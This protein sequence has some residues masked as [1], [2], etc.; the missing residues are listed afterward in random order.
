[1]TIFG[2]YN[3]CEIVAPLPVEEGVA[4]LLLGV[5]LRDLAD[6]PS[7]KLNRDCVL[8]FDALMY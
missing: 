6:N 3:P 5:G 8:R 1:M 4:M 2:S 7:V